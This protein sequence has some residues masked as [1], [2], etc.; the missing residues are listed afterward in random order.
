MS[1]WSRTV[2]EILALSI[3]DKY[4]KDPELGLKYYKEGCRLAASKSVPQIYNAFGT[5]LSFGDEALGPLAE[6]I[7]KELEN[8]I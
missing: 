2:Y 1:I 5:T 7:G 4:K 3:W 6:R 8:F